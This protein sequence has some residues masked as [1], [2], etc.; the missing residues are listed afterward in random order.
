M[1][2]EHATCVTVTPVQLD[3]R[4]A[5]NYFV[6]IRFRFNTKAGRPYFG[7][8]DCGLD[9]AVTPRKLVS[10]LSDDPT[11]AEVTVLSGG[12]VETVSEGR[13]S[14]QDEAVYVPDACWIARK[15]RVS[16]IIKHE[17]KEQ[18][19]EHA[20]EKAEED[21]RSMATVTTV[22]SVRGA[23]RA[24]PAEEADEDHDADREFCFEAPKDAATVA[25]G[26]PVHEATPALADAARGEPKN[27]ALNQAR[28]QGAVHSADRVTRKEREGKG[29]EQAASVNARDTDGDMPAGCGLLRSSSLKA[30]AKT[31]RR[32]FSRERLSR[33]SRKSGKM[34][35]RQASAGSTG[36]VEQPRKKRVDDYDDPELLLIQP[37]PIQPPRNPPANLQDTQV[38]P[39]RGPLLERE[40]PK[41]V[42]APPSE[43]G[44]ETRPDRE[45]ERDETVAR[46]LFRRTSNLA[47]NI[48]RKLS[49]SDKRAARQ[50]SEERREDPNGPDG[51]TKRRSLFGR[52]ESVDGMGRR[53]G[54]VV[55]EG[56][57]ESTQEPYR[58]H[59][60]RSLI[61]GRR[62]PN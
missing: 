58:V 56:S 32:S 28:E 3:P 7:E 6:D 39:Q 20:E 43:G 48:M 34:G 38:P 42:P 52:K 10:K 25:T 1:L 36:A 23:V 50:T 21:G 45:V 12:Q 22:T 46:G 4:S 59:K 16:S 61:F 53:P 44:V 49:S 18:L 33:T 19:V 47:R 24:L 62:Y 9:A 41:E 5:E 40:V 54:I 51:F 35:S 15:E 17:A 31:L 11:S 57:I 2:F 13:A 26:G 8:T 27:H 55:P 29:S 30:A 14:L 37:N 60:R